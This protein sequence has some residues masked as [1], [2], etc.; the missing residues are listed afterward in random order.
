MR[1]LQASR[2]ALTMI[3]VVM[4]LATL[5]IASSMILASVSFMETTAARNTTR[6]EAM[7]VAHRVIMQYIDEPDD[8]KQ[9]N[10]RYQYNR[11][12]YR[13]EVREEILQIDESTDI[14]G[15]TRREGALAKDLNMEDTF[16]SL[17]YQVTVTVYRE[18]P[19]YP[20]AIPTTPHT[21]LV[22]LYNP[23]S[24]FERD[25]D[26]LLDWITQ[27]LSGESVSLTEDDEQSEDDE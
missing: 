9:F 20:D 23:I 1:D 4:A 25:E 8:L 10:Q 19:N 24:L 22:R 5:V 13:F 7:E 16:K 27:V 12:F 26:R 21:Q 11:S 17:L 14:P 3:E 15:L 18:N 6:L 2:P